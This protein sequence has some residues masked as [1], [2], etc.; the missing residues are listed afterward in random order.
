MHWGRIY[1]AAQA[2]AGAAWWIA[3]FL[4]P[5]VRGVTLGS[6]DP[7]IIAVADIPLFVGASALA[8]FG[9][10]AAAG[11]STGWTV[12][13]TIALA[14]YATMT[15]EAGWGVLLMAAA[16]CGSVLALCLMWLGRVPTEWMLIGP[17][18]FRPADPKA[19]A[20]AHVAATAAQIGVFWGLFL[21]AIP[22]ALTF[23][24]QRWGLMIPFPPIANAA[25]VVLVVLAS[26]LGLWSAAAMSTRGGGTPLPAAMPN[27]LVVA[28]PYR[29]VRS[30]MAIAGFT[31]GVAV[32]LILSSWLVIAYAVAG[33]LYW[34][35]GVRPL[36][37]SDL[38]ARFGDEYRRYRSAVR[39]WWL[40]RTV[41]T[42]PRES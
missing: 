37:E 1:F 24:E 3:V 30:P 21:I 34:N 39:C 6:L 13:V 28:G 29:Y 10:R 36:E 5:F 11:V 18:S 12:V 15:S 26:A 20:I 16:A 35:F 33:A 14:V 27:R 32:G 41:F 31:Q 8:A 4:S 17:L 23:V 40:A 42:E 19:A 38:E 22:L 25:G 2:S 9:V 7:V